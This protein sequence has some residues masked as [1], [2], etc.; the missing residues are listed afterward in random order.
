MHVRVVTNITYPTNP[1][2]KLGCPVT[3][4]VIDPDNFERHTAVS[5]APETIEGQLGAIKQRY[6]HRNDR[7]TAG[8]GAGREIDLPP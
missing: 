2:K 8:R 7:R 5:E 1:R 6:D 3:R 4:R